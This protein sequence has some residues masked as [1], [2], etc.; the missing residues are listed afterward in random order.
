MH[1]HYAD[2][3]GVYC[4]VPR[5]AKHGGTVVASTTPSGSTV[6]FGQ[7]GLPWFEF[8]VER[9]LRELKREYDPTNPVHTIKVQLSTIGAANQVLQKVILS[10]LVSLKHVHPSIVN[11]YSRK[12]LNANSSQPLS[13]LRRTDPHEAGATAAASELVPP[14][15]PILCSMVGAQEPFDQAKM[16]CLPAPRS[17]HVPRRAVKHSRLRSFKA[18]SKAKHTQR[19]Y[20][21]SSDAAARPGAARLVCLTLHEVNSNSS[22]HE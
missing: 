3:R 9:R 20:R 1:M 10:G 12:Q 7:A 21:L 15:S 11:Y 17:L 5:Q 18:P 6:M 14:T 19:S 22:T 13:P 4:P 8:R 16:Q 2:M